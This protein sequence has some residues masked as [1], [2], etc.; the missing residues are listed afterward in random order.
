MIKTIC[1]LGTKR[2]NPRR[3]GMTL[4]EVL[5]SLAIF[6]MSIVAISTLVDIS[7]Q[8]A[9]DAEQRSVSLLVAES[10]IAEM[11]AGVTALTSS[12]GVWETDDR[13]TWSV[14]VQSMGNILYQ[15]TAS[16]QRDGAPRSKV[17]LVQYVADPQSLGSTMDAIPDESGSSSSASD[18][19]GSGSSS[20]A[21]PS[22]GSGTTGGGSS[23]TGPGSSG[24]KTSGGSTSGSKSSG[25]SSSGSKTITGGGSS[26][27]KTTGG[28]SSG[29][30]SK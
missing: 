30:K 14:D 8:Q 21:S 6:F 24:S 3:K 12:S 4:L 16:A 23:T 9:E 27:S 17:D 19:A 7:R 18:S 2:I 22:S 29:S 5:I 11:K 25:G 28:T 20:G 10:K 15:V 13:Y 1:P 26:G